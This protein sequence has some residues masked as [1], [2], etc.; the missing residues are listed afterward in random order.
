MGKPVEVEASETAVTT[1]SLS[2]TEFGKPVES[3]TRSTG[4]KPVSKDTV[5]GKPAE[6]PSQPT[7]TNPPFSDAEHINII[8]TSIEAMDLDSSP[9]ATSANSPKAPSVWTSHSSTSSTPSTKK[10]SSLSVLPV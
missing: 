9:A 8:G 3:P 7:A 5:T 6:I 10:A 2:N 1:W 4:M